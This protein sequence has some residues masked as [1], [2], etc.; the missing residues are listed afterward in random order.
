MISRHEKPDFSP[1]S[2]SRRDFL[3]S[4]M[5]TGMAGASGSLAMNPA[6]LHGATASGA[7]E[8]GVLSLDALSGDWM[9]MSALG[10]YPAINNFW[11]ALGVTDNL[12]AVTDLTFP[13]FSQGQH[14]GYL[15]INGEE[16]KAE[17]SR[18]YAYQILRRTRTT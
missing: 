4:L 3:Q 14:S 10:I 9:R 2:T 8:E 13:P 15:R 12:L 17:E 11:G 18:W 7:D 16:L 1:G 6:L 5:A